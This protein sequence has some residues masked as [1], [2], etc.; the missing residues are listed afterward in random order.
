MLLTTGNGLFIFTWDPGSDHGR[1]T[2]PGATY[3]VWTGSLLPLFWLTPAGG[4]PQA[5]KATVDP[6]RSQ[7]HARNA[8]L[9]LG[10]GEFGRGCLRISWAEDFF[11]FDSIAITWANP[12]PPAI[13][14]LYFGSS[15]LTTE[16]RAAAPSLEQ[17]FWPDWRAE[18]FSTPSAKTNPMQSFFRS[19]DFGHAVLPLGSF[20]PAM[21]TP[22][23]AAFPRPTY[24]ACLGGENGWLCAGAGAVPDGALSFRV[25]ARSATLERLYREE[26][27]GAPAGET[28]RWEAPLCL[29][30]DRVA[31]NAVRNYFRL[32]PD[33]APKS[34]VHQK[35]FWGT[36]GNFRL[37]QFDLRAAID[38]AADTAEPDVLCV[39]DPWESGKGSCRPH[40][41]K[42]PQCQADIAHAHA[43]GLGVGIWMPTGWLA[44][45]AA[46]GLTEDDLLL[47][48]DGVPIRSNWAI[49]PRETDQR[50][51]CLDPSS[52]A[53][54]LFLRERTHRVIREYQP[55]LLKVDFAYGLPGPDACMPRDPH[56]R[57]EQLAWNY[58]RLIAAAAHE[59]NP[60]ITILGYSLQ[61]LWD[62]VQDE[63]ALDD[64]GDAGMHEAAGHGHWS[65]WAALAGERGLALMGSSGY[66]WAADD[67]VMLNTAVLGAP[68]MNLSSQEIDGATSPRRARRRGLFRWFRRTT[69]WSPLWLDSEP[70]TLRAEPCIRNWGRLE[71]I[72]GEA[73]LTALALRE[74]A[75]ALRHEPALRGLR[76]QGRWAVLAQGSGSIFTAPV[77]ALIP[78]AAGA[79]S[80]ARARRPGSVHA[81]FVSGACAYHDWDWQDG[82]LRITVE[83]SFLHHPLLGFLI[84]DA[85]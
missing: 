11:R 44:D 46:E 4:S 80:L 40:P 81:V 68:G 79:I 70:G 75:D 58:Q 43:R 35:S 45:Y 33:G 78:F 82:C 55:T 50:F 67:E 5:V 31:W 24:A 14:A 30:W 59:L 34:L 18:G 57:G 73:V 9:D 12:T 64:L 83:E 47:S 84:R 19:W 56:Y 17:P 85:L 2:V 76:W 8:E 10:L 63:C 42:L 15:L 1:L 41:G 27:W 7:V 51:Y 26:Y 13:S 60:D 77:T 29:T 71:T 23:A 65:V 3:P 25:R 49:D 52:A 62:D 21:G 20:G 36:W 39:D 54:R 69:Q 16:E 32:L 37:G 61:P 38:F 72:G 22:Y 74:P 48:R 6:G 28:R 53:A 66:L